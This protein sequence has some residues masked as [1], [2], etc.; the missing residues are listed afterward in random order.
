VA[1]DDGATART[2]RRAG[3]PARAL[4]KAGEENKTAQ[5]PSWRLGEAVGAVTWPETWSDGEGDDEVELHGK[6]SAGDGLWERNLRGKTSTSGENHLGDALDTL[7]R[8]FDPLTRPHDE[9]R[10]RLCAGAGEQRGR[11]RN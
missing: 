10:R 11:R 3:V 8:A 6:G 5:R 9:R 4:E 1:G 2:G 7:Y